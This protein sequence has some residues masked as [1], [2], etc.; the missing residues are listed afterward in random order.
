VAR[1]EGKVF[2][3]FKK[4][5]RLVLHVGTHKTGTTSIQRA[6]F[7]SREFDRSRG[8]IYPLP[9]LAVT[10]AR[11]SHHFLAH[12]LQRYGE[13]ERAAVDKFRAEILE[14][15]PLGQTIVISA[16]PFYRHVAGMDWTSAEWSDPKKYWPARVEYLKRVR[17]W[18]SP[19]ETTVLLFLREQGAF[20]T[21]LAG[22]LTRKNEWS[23][24][25]DD[26]R[27]RHSPQ[28]FDYDRQRTLLRKHL[29]PVTTVDYDDA[30]RTGGSVPAFYQA[31][32]FDAPEGTASIRERVSADFEPDSE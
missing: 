22:E 27:F 12:Y 23:G 7:D 19:F 28:L 8:L 3:L 20:A 18:L 5:P 21:S 10:K 32:G 24:S 2:G 11:R 9:S 13:V 4:K 6:L 31:I 30:L 1:L 14:M 25:A 15:E 17:R 16:E 26:F 29:G